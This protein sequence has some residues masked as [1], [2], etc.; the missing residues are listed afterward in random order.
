MAELP[1]ARCAECGER[2]DEEKMGAK[3][4]RYYED[5]SGRLF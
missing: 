4:F 3:R 2:G 1:Q 5:K